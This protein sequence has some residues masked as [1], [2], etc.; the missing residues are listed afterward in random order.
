MAA[1]KPKTKA[2]TTKAAGRTKTAGGT[3]KK[4]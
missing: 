2:K 4:A 1:T 3:K